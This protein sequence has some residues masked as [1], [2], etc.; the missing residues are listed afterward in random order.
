VIYC[1]VGG[2]QAA[3]MAV[4]ARPAP[5]IAAAYDWSGF[6]IGAS[7]GYGWAR[8][9]GTTAN[10]DGDFPAPYSLD[11]TGVMGG[12]FLGGNYQ[13]KSVV[14]G[15]EADWQAANLNAGGNFLLAPTTYRNETRIK[16][17]GSARG[18]LG[19]AIERW[20]L[21]GTAGVAWGSWDTSYA[22]AGLNP[23]YTNRVTHHVGWTAGAGVEYAFLDNWL[24]RAEYRYTDLGS[25]T[26][27][28]GTTVIAPNLS[29]PGNRVTINDVRVGIA[30]K[31]GHTPVARQ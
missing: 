16:D 11:P 1:G 9:N 2:A 19:F 6:Y 26:F 28:A 13:I 7:V 20:M 3:D 18:R 31:F 17:Y 27:V 29:D 22:I 5:R 25:S 23:F 8:S 12:G 14:L 15:I 10:A 4:K 30:Y 21:F 24:A